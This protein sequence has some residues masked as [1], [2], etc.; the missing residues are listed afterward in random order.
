MSDS[1]GDANEVDE[2]SS[3][4]ED[5]QVC[6][7]AGV[8]VS[9]APDRGDVALSADVFEGGSMKLLHRVT[10]ECVDISL[11]ASSDAYL[12]FDEYGM[13]YIDP[14]VDA[15]D[16]LWCSDLFTKSVYSQGGGNRFLFVSD[17]AMAIEGGRSVH[18]VWQEDLLRDHDT[19]L[20]SVKTG[21][22]KSAADHTVA[23]FRLPRSRCRL[24][25]SVQ[26]IHSNCSFTAYG[27]KGSAK[28]TH[29]YLARWDAELLAVGFPIGILRSLQYNLDDSA[30]GVTEEAS[31]CLP[32]VATPSCCL[33][34]RLGIL[35]FAEHSCKG[36]A[37][38]D[39]DVLSA[40]CYLQAVMS[41]A[42]VA[43]WSL[44][45]FPCDMSK[46]A[47]QPWDGIL[48]EEGYFEVPVSAGGDVAA[49]A[50]LQLSIV[51]Q[52]AFLHDFLQAAATRAK[53]VS[54]DGLSLPL[55][56]LLGVACS[57][58]KRQ[59]VGNAAAQLLLQLC[60]Q[61]GARMQKVLLPEDGCAGT[62]MPH[63]VG[64]LQLRPKPLV[65]NRRGVDRDRFLVGYWTAGAKRVGSHALQGCSTFF[66]FSR[67][68]GRNYMVSGTVAFDN[69]VVFHP[70][71][72]VRVCEGGG[73][74]AGRA[75]C[76]GGE[77]RPAW[78]IWAAR[79]LRRISRGL[80]YQNEFSF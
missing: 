1:R 61:V 46:G 42:S 21:P 37:R 30:T 58:Y 80:S 11:M 35:G 5:E 77:R 73:G 17:M 23:V 79:G 16:A 41:C 12:G 49:H 57:F 7:A 71:Q 10:Q 72:V 8:K 36:R 33:L 25:W 66:D 54:A 56:E 19:L 75:S 18:Q 59:K 47:F 69:A 15:Q 20:C 67:V 48:P 52:N 27:E 45:I 60:W 22:C 39:S 44:Y 28:W 62:C 65:T 2:I 76:H 51:Q 78:P 32:F 70:V 63:S 43:E 74:G 31:R 26:E 29:N 3:G 4:G 53:V 68:G 24:F 40:R 38:S 14:G 9:L 34:F 50:L 13:G 64:D 55:F 6:G